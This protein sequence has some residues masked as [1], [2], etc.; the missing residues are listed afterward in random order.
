MISPVTKWAAK[1][2]KAE[3]DFRFKHVS[4]RNYAEE[5]AFYRAAD[6]E[7]ASC[8]EAFSVL[9]NRQ[10]R[11]VLWQFPTQVFQYFFNYY[12]GVLSYA[13]QIF[14]IFIFKTYADLD[15]ASL[16]EKISNNAFYYI[17][18]INSFTRLTDL[19]LSIGELGGY[20]LRVSEIVNC[21][22][23]KDG[24]DNEG[25]TEFD[26]NDNTQDDF[27]FDNDSAGFDL[28]FSVRGL[29]YG[30]PCDDDDILVS[31]EYSY[32]TVD[33]PVN[34]NLIITGPSGAG[35]SSLLRV[36]ANLWPSKAGT[37]R[38]CL[39]ESA[40]FFLPQRPYLPVGRLCL[41]KQ[42]C[43]PHTP[44][45]TIDDEKDAESRRLVQILCDLRLTS[46]IETCG[47]LDMDVDFEWQ[48]TLSPGEQQRLSF[49]RV[50]F[51]SPKVAVLDEATSSIDVEDERNLYELLKENKISYISTGHRETLPHFHDIELKLGRYFSSTALC[52]HGQPPALS[53]PEERSDTELT[54]MG[55][56]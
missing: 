29:S 16:G 24:L 3:G 37:I 19:A 12:G 55:R 47:G 35:K 30:K 42:M 41:R 10:L 2:E 52:A 4:I 31:D 44:A 27:L 43:F 46:L 32:L 49:A 8:D 39:P 14:P 18:L 15:D 45:Y 26:D 5:S 7:K 6:F 22:T 51:H 9:W 53:S 56:M 23:E 54:L 11:F 50:L 1:V 38:R 17:Y 48:D 20:V 21:T 28:S 13:I 34:K 36:L 40:Y 33:V 25:F